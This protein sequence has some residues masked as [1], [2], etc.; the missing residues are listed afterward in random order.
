MLMTMAEMILEMATAKTKMTT[1]MAK[2]TPMMMTMMMM[3]RRRRGTERMSLC[4]GD[5]D[6]LGFLFSFQIIAMYVL[7]L[8]MWR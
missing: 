5:N 4:T 6:D 8:S 3:M 1:M 2:M 7:C